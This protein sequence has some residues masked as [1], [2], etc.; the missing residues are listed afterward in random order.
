M[1][2]LFQR[3]ISYLYRIKLIISLLLPN[4]QILEWYHQ[5]QRKISV[6]IGRSKMLPFL[7]LQT[8]FWA[9]ATGLD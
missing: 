9:C 7:L 6:P 2:N 3:Q 4:V 5:L 8:K 1:E